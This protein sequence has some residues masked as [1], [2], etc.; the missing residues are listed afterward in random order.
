MAMQSGTVPLGEVLQALA[1]V[2]NGEL[3]TLLSPDGVP[4]PA[5]VL[6]EQLRQWSA[7]AR[8]RFAEAAALPWAVERAD[9]LLAAEGARARVR[10]VDARVAEATDLSH[11]M[12]SQLYALQA[13]VSVVARANADRF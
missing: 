12:H 2:T 10:R 6:R 13:R 9:D 11:M 8:R 3:R 4:P 5:G 1:S 7:T